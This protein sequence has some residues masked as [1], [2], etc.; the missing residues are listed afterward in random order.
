MPQPPARH[1]HGHGRI[2]IYRTGRDGTCQTRLSIRK[3]E[4]NQRVA[5][6][7]ILLHGNTQK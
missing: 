1:P 7:N 5:K 2:T 3:N 4:K 6:V